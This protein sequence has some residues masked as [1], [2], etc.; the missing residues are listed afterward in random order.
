MPVHFL[1]R[2][3]CH[4]GRVAVQ[5]HMCRLCMPA[6]CATVIVQVHLVLLSCVTRVD[7]RE[8]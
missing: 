1:V 5:L 6:H 4:S 2:S 8:R 7:N 3:H